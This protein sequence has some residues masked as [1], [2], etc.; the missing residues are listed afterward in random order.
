M[1]NIQD[2]FEKLGGEFVSSP[3]FMKEKLQNIKALVFDWDGV[4]HSGYKDESG[5]SS[6]SESDSMG[7][8]MLRFGLYLEQNHQQPFSAIIT[9]ENN[10]TA[11]YWGK[12]EHLNGVF[13]KIKNKVELLPFLKEEYG[14]NP[15]EILFVFDDILDLSLAKECGLRMLVQKAA[16]PLFIQYCI[17]NNLC[18][19]VTGSS[20]SE[21]ALREISELC[22]SLLGR[23]DETIDK[24]M[25]FS[26][27]YQPY[28]SNR[29]TIPT[30]IY[31]LKEGVV[32]KEV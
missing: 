31:T 28:I 15:D 6:F 13:F 18:D 20:A 11:F 3:F 8:N 19:Y 14:V 16:N 27:D 22:L 30:N 9:G 1:D 12:R 17:K 23:L 29:N 32:N 24:R 25:E 10:K 5:S 21:H 26:G 4:F 2:T 7:I